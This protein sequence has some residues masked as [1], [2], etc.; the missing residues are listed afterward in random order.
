MLK[1]SALLVSAG[2]LGTMAILNPGKGSH[3][4]FI[5]SY[6]YEQ[7]QSDKGFCEDLELDVNI[8]FFRR[9]ASV[10]ID[11]ADA[12]NDVRVVSRAIF[13]DK[14]LENKIKAE[15]ALAEWRNFLLGS[16]FRFEYEGTV[17]GTV[18]VLGK[19]WVVSEV[20]ATLPDTVT[21]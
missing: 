2:L 4:N 6:L 20:P 8:G 21:D 11:T 12:C 3:Q 14:N 1:M 15:A 13:Q 19:M 9:V 10:L 5:A 16:L 18:G 17:Y 7:K